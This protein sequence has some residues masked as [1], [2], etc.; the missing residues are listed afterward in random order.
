MMGLIF[1]CMALALLSLPCISYAGWQ[2]ATPQVATNSEPFFQSGFSS[3]NEVTDNGAF[4]VAGSPF[5]QGQPVSGYAITVNGS[6]KENIERIMEGYHW[7]VVW[8]SPNDYRYEGRITGASLPSVIEK[9]LSPFP[10]KAVMYM[11]NRTVAI[12]ERNV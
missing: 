10:L 12:S 4:P 2:V 3:S 5:T 8:L 9:L 11:S 1:R 7:R 6:V